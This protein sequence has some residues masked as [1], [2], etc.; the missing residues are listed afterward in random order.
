MYSVSIEKHAFNNP[1]KPFW[2][3]SP[4]VILFDLVRLQRVRPW[5]VDLSYLLTTLVHELKRGGFIDLTASGIALFSSATIYRMKSELILE[6]QE[7]PPPP[8]EKP[9]EFDSPPIQLPFRYE[10]TTTTVE[11]LLKALDEALK[12]EGLVELQ[13]RLIPVMPTSPVTQEIDEFMVDIENK[14]EVMYQ[15]ISQLGSKVISFSKLTEGLTRLESIRVFLLI[16]FLASRGQIQLWQNEGFDE[17]YLS[18]QR[19]NS[20]ESEARVKI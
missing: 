8:I 18:I 4:W 7:P 1:E 16:L 5:N 6:L 3:R 19:R 13:P 2:L 17:I 20:N 11:S 14:I 9:I 15:K 12:D 10:Y